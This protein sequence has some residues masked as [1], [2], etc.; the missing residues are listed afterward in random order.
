MR[1][2]SAKRLLAFSKAN[3]GRGLRR[4]GKACVVLL[5]PIA[6]ASRSRR[7]ASVDLDLKGARIEGLRAAVT[8]LK[9]EGLMDRR[10]L[11]VNSVAV[12]EER[13]R[14]SGRQHRSITRLRHFFRI[15]RRVKISESGS[16]G[17]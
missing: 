9:A 12:T 2:R 6:D 17:P 13:L 11:D 16:K 7:L 5:A 1:H 14:R 8:R 10:P 4:Q 15:N 3:E